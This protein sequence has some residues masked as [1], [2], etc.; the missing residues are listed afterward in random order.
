[1]TFV[2]WCVLPALV[3]PAFLLALLIV[4]LF[5]GGCGGPTEVDRD[6]GRVLV[7]I[8][9]AITLKNPRLL[10]A[11]SVRAQS[12]HEAGQLADAEYEAMQGCI[13]KGRSGDWPAA[14]SEAY[15]FHKRHPFVRSGQ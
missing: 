9:T 7:E 6:N 12:R 8:M 13:E 2:R 15:A 5:A 14:E 1:M 3:L 4:L 11:S 10:E